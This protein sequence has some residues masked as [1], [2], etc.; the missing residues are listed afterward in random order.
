MLGMYFIMLVCSLWIDNYLQI[1]EL[2]GIIDDYELSKVEVDSIFVSEECLD[3]QI[4]FYQKIMNLDEVCDY[5]LFV[6]FQVV[7]KNYLEQYDKVFEFY[8]EKCFEEV[9]KFVVGLLIEYWCEGC[10]YF[11]EMIELNKDIVDCV[12]DNIV[13]VVDDVELSMLVILLLVVVVVGICGFLLLWV[14]I[15]LIQKIVCSFDLMVGGDFIVCLNFGWCDEFGVIEIGFN[16][17]VEE[18]KG[19]VLQVQCFLVQVIILV[20]EIVVIFKQQQ[21]IVIEIVVIIMEIGVIF[22]EIVVILCDLVWIMSEVF[23]VVEQILI[24]V[25]FGQ[26][27]LV[28]ME[29]IMYYVMGVVDLV[30]VKLVIFN[31][32]VGNINQVVIIIVKVVDQINLFLLNV[33]IEVEKV[34]EYGCGFVVVVIEVCWLVDQIVVVIYDIEQMVCEIQ[35]VVLVGVMG[36]DKFFEE[37]CCGI[38][39]VGQVGE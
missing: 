1:Q 4:V 18:F 23:G 20:I 3:Q 2:F 16:G 13:N 36:M 22:C 26:L 10:K 29:E 38:V 39:E 5:E 34:G 25:G 15:Q 6:G 19:L 11:N 7:C 35:L 12:L 31:E 32:K 14:I 37:V 17:M 33:V 24:L 28:C 9:G 30:N 8:C 21:V 27:G